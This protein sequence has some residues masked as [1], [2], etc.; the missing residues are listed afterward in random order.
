MTYDH[1]L[2]MKVALLVAIAPLAVN[3]VKDIKAWMKDRAYSDIP[4][5]LDKWREEREE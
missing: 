5:R 4:A 1:E 3:V 2:A